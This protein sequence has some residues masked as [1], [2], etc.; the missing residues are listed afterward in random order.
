MAR[1]H[2]VWLQGSHF[3][4]LR[5]PCAAL[6][7]G[8]GIRCPDMHIPKHRNVAN[9]GFNRWYPKVRTMRQY[10]LVAA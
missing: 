3:I 1:N 8:L 5:D 7:C 6:L 9:H 2:D 4:K 10:A